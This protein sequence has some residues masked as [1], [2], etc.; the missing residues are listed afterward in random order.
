MGKIWMCGIGTLLLS[1]SA[2][3]ADSNIITTVETVYDQPSAKASNLNK[4]E[5]S[6]PF[7]VMQFREKFDRA[8]ADE[9]IDTIKSITVDKTNTY[10]VTLNDAAFQ[11]MVMAMKKIDA[12]NGPFEEKVHVL[13]TATSDGK[14]DTILIGGDRSDPMNMLLTISLVGNI[15]RILSPGI[16]DDGV[17][18]MVKDFGLMRGDSDPTIGEPVDIIN[19][20]AEFRCNNQPTEKSYAMGCLILPRS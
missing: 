18:D 16:T 17:L 2:Y 5:A 3:G 8:A 15:I 1:L 4:N 7:T 6:F 19:K 9:K 11:K 20:V 13:L 10:L 12:V 14:V